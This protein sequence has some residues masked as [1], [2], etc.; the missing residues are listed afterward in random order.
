MTAEAGQPDNKSNETWAERYLRPSPILLTKSNQYWVIVASANNEGEGRVVIQRLKEK[1]PKYDF[2]LW[3]P[4]P[5]SVHWGIMMATWVSYQE[6]VE[7]RNLARRDIN[8][9]SYIWA[10]CGRPEL[11]C[12]ETNSPHRARQVQ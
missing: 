5:P 7:V 6:S 10:A 12:G 11:T 3:S 4:F 8:K 1:Y 9:T 2:A